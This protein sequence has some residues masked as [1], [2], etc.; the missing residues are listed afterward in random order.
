MS[1]SNPPRIGMLAAAATEAQSTSTKLLSKMAATCAATAF[2]T[3]VV[4]TAG[5]VVS[6]S[7]VKC[8]GCPFKPPWALTHE[9]QAWAVGTPCCV[10]EDKGPVQLHIS[11][12]ETGLPLAAPAGA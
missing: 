5:L 1:L 6:S 7:T 10:D 8:T 4:A 9:A 11:S 12:T 2:S 3:W